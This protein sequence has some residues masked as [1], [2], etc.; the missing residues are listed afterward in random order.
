VTIDS[1]AMVATSM[2]FV[3]VGILSVNAFDMMLNV[4][5]IW[6]AAGATRAPN[7]SDRFAQRP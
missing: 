3:I 6:K 2:S 7:A 4:P 5:A 1:D